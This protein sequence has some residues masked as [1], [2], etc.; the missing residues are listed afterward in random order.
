MKKGFYLAFIILLITSSLGFGQIIQDIPSQKKQTAK[1]QM[2]GWNTVMDLGKDKWIIWGAESPILETRTYSQSAVI[3]SEDPITGR[4]DHL[5]YDRGSF[6]LFE[7]SIIFTT[8]SYQSFTGDYD[9][10]YG[11]FYYDYDG[12][13]YR[14]RKTVRFAQYNHNTH[15][16]YNNDKEL[17]EWLKRELKNKNTNYPPVKLE[18]PSP[19]IEYELY[20]Y[21]DKD[22]TNPAK[23]VYSL[24]D[25]KMVKTIKLDSYPTPINSDMS[26]KDYIESFVNHSGFVYDNGKTPVNIHNLYLEFIVAADGDVEKL[27]INGD[28][29]DLYDSDRKATFDAEFNN[30]LASIINNLKFNPGKYKGKPVRTYC[31]LK[32]HFDKDLNEKQKYKGDAWIRYMNG[33]YGI[34]SKT[35]G[36]LLDYEWDSIIKITDNCLLLSKD[37]ASGFL[38][39]NKYRKIVLYDKIIQMDDASWKVYKNNKSGILYGYD[40][41]TPVLYDNII[42]INNQCWEVVSDGVHGIQYK[43]DLVIPVLYDRIE[44]VNNFFKPT[45]SYFKAINGSGI[46]LYDIYF[47]KLFTCSNKNGISISKMNNAPLWMTESSKK[48]GILDWYGKE[49]LQ[50]K[51]D[52]IE[53]VKLRYSS[54]TQKVTDAMIYLKLNDR[55]SIVKCTNGVINEPKVWFEE[56]YMPKANNEYYSNTDDNMDGFENMYWVRFENQKIWALIKVNDNSS[57]ETII[58][59]KY[60]KIIKYNVVSKGN[61]QYQI[62]FEKGKVKNKRIK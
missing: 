10:T 17:V 31:C 15:I 60:D 19:Y 24:P 44:K 45:D 25:D 30:W 50:C 28:T 9:W 62:S 27:T 49:L 41:Q 5:E 36:I 34:V 20:P 53:F 46:T 38:Y 4:W 13:K 11:Y 32:I 18:I 39:G 14:N 33:K 26:M 3:G 2:Q 23:I 8:H 6:F 35:D 56:I 57:F 40:Y 1:E 12:H 55:Y 7:N 42:Q 54:D 61:N 48:H 58:E 59:P 43:S 47:K 22:L 29:F 21:F 16:C 52:K 37:G 51:Y